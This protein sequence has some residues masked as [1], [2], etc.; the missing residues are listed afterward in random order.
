[1]YDYIIVGAGSAGCVLAHRLSAEPTTRVLLIEAGPDANPFWSRVPAGVGS[2]FFNPTYNW[3]YK[4]EEEVALGGRKVYWPRGKMTGGSSAI[5]GMTYIRGSRWDYDNWRSQGNVGWGWNDVLPYF[6]RAETSDIGVDDYRGREG[7]VQVTR[8]KYRPPVLDAVVQSARAS[9]LPFNPDVNGA[10]QEGVG[11]LQHTI[12]GGR[13][14]STARAYLDPVRG[15]RNL[16]II[17]MA[18]VQKV[19]IENGCAVGIRLRREGKDAEYRGREIIVSAG[20]VNSPQLLM[21]S[22]IGPAGDLAG[23]GIE[24]KRDLPGVGANLQ[25]H[26]GANTCFET[27]RGMSLNNALSGW[28]KYLNGARYLVTKSGPLSLGVAQVAAFVKSS[29][30]EPSADLQISFRT[31]S[32][33]FK[34]PPTLKLHPFPGVQ[35]MAMLIRPSSAGAITLANADPAAAPIINASYLTAQGDIE[36]L[37]EGVRWVRRVMNSEPMRSIVRK[38]IEPGAGHVSDEDLGVYLRANANSVYHPVGTCKMGH[39]PMAVVDARLRVHGVPG[40]RVVDASIMPT[41]VGG[42]TNAPTIMIAERAADLILE[43]AK[44]SVS[45]SGEFT[46]RL[47]AAS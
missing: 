24:V 10:E 29:E 30:A 5:N 1:M 7:P 17:D 23:L 28:H 38:E 2:M 3:M 26:I 45:G 32:L 41:I 18:L 34:N 35:V 15:R 19:L 9:G 14:S 47:A 12:G 11:Y 46:P 20:A 31:W 43:D 36:R 8:S 39:D 42:N 22:G 37:S 21:L 27:R 44:R 33:D 16:T 4:T 13:R 40:L 6:K 25:D